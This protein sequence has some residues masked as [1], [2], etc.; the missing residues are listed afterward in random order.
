MSMGI[1]VDTDTNIPYRFVIAICKT[2][3]KN[4]MEN[5]GGPLTMYDNII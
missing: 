4:K 5:R 2:F 1:Q 3:I